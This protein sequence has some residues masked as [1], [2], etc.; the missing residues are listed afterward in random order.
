MKEELNKLKDRLQVERQKI[1]SRLKQ[2]D[3]D[4]ASIERVFSL[5][6]KQAS[7]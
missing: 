1:A 6:D 4:L 7:S 3:D 2:I 5:V